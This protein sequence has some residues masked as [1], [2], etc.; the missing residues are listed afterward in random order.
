MCTS[1]FRSIGPI[2]LCLILPSLSQ[3]QPPMRIAYPTFPPFHWTDESGALKGFFYEIVSE[4]LEKRMGQK[5]VWTAYPWI[6]CQENLKIGQADAIITVP[7]AARSAYTVTHRRPI[8]KKPLNL[9]T[10]SDH[11]RM[12]E[13][14][15]IGGIADMGTSGFSVI[16]YS[17]NG[18]HNDHVRSQG[19]RTYE[20]AILKNVWK[21]LA[22]KRGDLVIEWPPGAW[23]DIIGEGVPDRIVDTR[24][25]I[26][27]MPF[28]V[29]IRKNA[30]MGGL[31]ADLDAVIEQME[32]EGT[33][34]AILDRYY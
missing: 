27:E 7:T 17:G 30:P 9:F 19:V 1:W 11:P 26:A 8:Y 34:A 22:E 25:T 28:H 14:K 4:A 21:M 3:G 12:P 10:Y 5:L 15:A 29:L 20:V 23:P 32:K 18:W 31:L 2:L 24:K 33:I 16:T 6:R 13:I